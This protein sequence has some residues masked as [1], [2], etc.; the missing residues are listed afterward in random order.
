MIFWNL[1]SSAL[2]FSIYSRYSSKVVEPIH[3]NSPLA[4]IGF[5]RLAAS[6]APSL[7]PAPTRLCISSINIMILPSAFFTSFKT[8][9]NLSSNSPRYFA[10]A[11][12][13]PISSSIN[14]LSLRDEGTSPFIIRHASPSTIAVLPTP[15]SPIKTGLFLVLRDSIS[16]TRRISSSRPITG[17]ILPFFTSSTRS[18]PYF[19]SGLRLFSSSLFIIFCSPLLSLSYLS[20]ISLLTFK[21][22]IN[23]LATAELLFKRQ[24]KKVN[25]D[26]YSS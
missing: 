15:G 24:I 17:S 16:T 9:F 11:I 25:N 3:F 19:L 6:I 22:L 8:A 26:I 13:E 1:L 20:S 18:R 23:S 5:K 21:T 12:R 10:P 4:S 7:L 2:S 14:C